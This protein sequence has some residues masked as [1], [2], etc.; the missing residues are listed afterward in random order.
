M[1]IMRKAS[2]FLLIVT[3]ITMLM[4]TN[5]IN[6]GQFGSFVHAQEN[7]D[8]GPLLSQIAVYG[9]LVQESDFI[10]NTDAPFY[11]S[12]LNDGD[13]NATITSMTVQ[14]TPQLGTQAATLN[15]TIYNISTPISRHNTLFPKEARTYTVVNNLSTVPS[16]S[17]NI[18]MYVSITVGNESG[19]L[20][21]ITEFPILI[22]PE[23]GEGVSPIT[24]LLIFAVIVVIILGAVSY[25]SIRKIIKN[26]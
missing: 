3:M 1:T 17:Y 9:G 4:S 24:V 10:R 7:E 15:A 8:L 26:R 22:F 2:V 20:Y 6:R 11:T 14:L 23:E 12:V 16:G 13:V 21:S 19:D 25:P 18:S 5:V